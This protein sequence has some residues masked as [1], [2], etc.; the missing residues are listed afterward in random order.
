MWEYDTYKDPVD[1][2]RDVQSEY[3][4][5]LDHTRF[6]NLV[7]VFTLFWGVKDRSY[8]LNLYPSQLL[9]DGQKT[10]YVSGIL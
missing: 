4:T 9:Y 6:D 2:K 5:C 7:S 3:W 1:D 8:E 10:Y